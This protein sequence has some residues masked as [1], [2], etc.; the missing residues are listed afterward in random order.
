MEKIKILIADDHQMFRDG[1]KLVLK[2]DESFEL[3]GEAENGEVAIKLV[4]ELNPDVV[5][6]DINMPKKNGI[7]ATKII[8]SK[9]KNA[10][11]LILTMH[12]N[13]TFVRDAVNAGVDGYILKISA[14]NE[15]IRAVKKVF[16][17]KSYF[18][19]SVIRSVLDEYK[20][21]KTMGVTINKELTNRERE[22]LYHIANG[23]T[24]QQIAKELFISYHTVSEH[25]KN[26]LKKLNLKNTAD[27][28]RYSI[29]NGIV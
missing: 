4:N 27:L 20:K 10:K 2:T 21:Q 3:I 11:V 29:E 12:E 22:I 25:R 15:L 6:L 23:K 24:S 16:S 14:M 26:I 19:E 7:E 17:G 9:N 5:I 13:E 8:K 28:I 1:L 18:P